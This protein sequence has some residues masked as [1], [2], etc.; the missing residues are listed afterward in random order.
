MKKRVVTKAEFDRMVQDSAKQEFNKNIRLGRFVPM[1]FLRNEARKKLEPTCEI[2]GN[3]TEKRERKRPLPA[4]PKTWILEVDQQDVVL[5]EAALKT[6]EIRY[7][8]K[9]NQ[10]FFDNRI[11]M[12]R[13]LAALDRAR[14]QVY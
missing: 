11:E 5:A 4:K 6:A 3:S 10:F 9:E 2:L 12:S 1:P 13:A 7:E 8:G 14:I